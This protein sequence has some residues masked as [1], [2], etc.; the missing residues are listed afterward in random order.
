[1]T[2][3]YEFRSLVKVETTIIY[4]SILY[5]KVQKSI[6]QITAIFFMRIFHFLQMIMIYQMIHIETALTYIYKMPW[7]LLLR[8]VHHKTYESR[9]FARSNG[10][11]QFICTYFLRVFVMTAPLLS[12][13]FS[14]ISNEKKKW[15]TWIPKFVAWWLHRYVACKQS[16]FRWLGM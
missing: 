14:S 3:Y 2:I 4:C 12:V 13:N 16:H 9:T 1:M 15:R 8:C 11:F 6:I 10:R 7:V 5:T